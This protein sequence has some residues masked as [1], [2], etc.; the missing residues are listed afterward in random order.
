MNIYSVLVNAYY[1]LIAI[2]PPVIQWLLTV[3]LL[4]GVAILFWHLITRNLLFLIIL[5]I[6]LPFLIPVL[7]NVFAGIWDFILF[8]LVQVGIRTPPPA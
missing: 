1:Q 5:V 4:V 8:L 6:L 7:W 3:A 2:F